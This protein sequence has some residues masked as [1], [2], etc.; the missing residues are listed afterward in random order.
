MKIAILLPGQTRTYNK[1]YQN[2][3]KHFENYECDIYSS[4]WDIQ[5]KVKKKNYDDKIGN[6]YF[7]DEPTSEIVEDLR[8]M[9]N[10]KSFEIESYD[11]WL[12]SNLKHIEKF[13][14]NHPSVNRSML[15][16]GIFAQYYKIKKTFDMIKNPNQ[17]DIIVKY[18]YDIVSDEI[19]LVQNNKLNCG[20][21]TDLNFPTDWYF[22]GNPN[23]ML[24][25]CNMYEWLE[26]LQP[27]NPR[28]VSNDRQ[29]TYTPEQILGFFV[30][31]KNIEV[32][33]LDTNPKCVR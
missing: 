10:F 32:N 20:K 26:E 33:N 4:V 30:K 17:Y 24:K 25:A 6:K 8:M 14:E 12:E 18:R 29:T 5:G 16:N 22:Y 13:K 27:Y 11:G 1:C 21:L 28:E 9:Y 23:V 19:D 3:L 31:N 7:S 15:T 2:F